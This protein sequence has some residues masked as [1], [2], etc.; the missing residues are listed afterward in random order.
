V[1]E[2][3]REQNHVNISF[4]GKTHNLMKTSPAVVA[5]DRVAL[6]VAN[7]IVGGN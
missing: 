6:I 7:M 5:S 4:F 3:T 2:V 1:E